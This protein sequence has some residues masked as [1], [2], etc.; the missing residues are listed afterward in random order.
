[1]NYTHHTLTVKGGDIERRIR[2]INRLIH[3]NGD[4]MLITGMVLDPETQSSH[5]VFDT[6]GGSPPYHTLVS[7]STEFPECVF[8][9]ASVGDLGQFT[10]LIHFENGQEVVEELDE[11]PLGLSLECTECECNR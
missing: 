6:P 5:L 4:T 2:A 11:D 8:R 1:M 7:F 9:L 3:G 10:S